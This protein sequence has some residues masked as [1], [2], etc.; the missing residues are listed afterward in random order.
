MFKHLW[1][2]SP[3]DSSLSVRVFPSQA[4]GDRHER[5]R[6]RHIRA[7]LLRRQEASSVAAHHPGQFTGESHPRLAPHWALGLTHGS[8][9][10]WIIA[11]QDCRTRHNH[12]K[13]W[14][15]QFKS[16]LNRYICKL[17]HY[18]YTFLLWL[19]TIISR[20]SAD[21]RKL[22]KEM[23]LTDKIIHLYIAPS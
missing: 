21:P 9:F 12:W 23:L 3:I 1:V 19:E 20:R 10:L 8:L 4:E 2:E 15:R 11:A 13:V 17:R 18:F 6:R 14:K 7:L 16:P 5:V 22:K